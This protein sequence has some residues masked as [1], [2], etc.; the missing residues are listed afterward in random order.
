MARLEQVVDEVL[1][2]LHEAQRVFGAMKFARPRRAP[3]LM[4]A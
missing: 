2:Q 4:V 3:A 1:W